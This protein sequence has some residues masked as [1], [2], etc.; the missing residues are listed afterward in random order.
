MSSSRNQLKPV[1]G[2]KESNYLTLCLTC[3]SGAEWAVG[4]ILEI[5]VAEKEIK[6]FPAGGFGYY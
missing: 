5:F 6:R 4:K 2:K 1:G 3:V